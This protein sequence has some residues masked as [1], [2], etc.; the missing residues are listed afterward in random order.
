MKFRND[1]IEKCGFGWP[2]PG[3][4]TNIRG[5]VLEDSQSREREEGLRLWSAIQ[6]VEE[7]SLTREV[8]KTR[9]GEDGS[10]DRGGNTD[11]DGGSLISVECSAVVQVDG[12]CVQ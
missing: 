2:C 4:A 6:R 9:M 3:L 10:D 1:G 12:N 11:F 8:A 7:A 5:L